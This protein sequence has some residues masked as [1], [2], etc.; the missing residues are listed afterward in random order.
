MEHSEL[1]RLRTLPKNSGVNLGTGNSAEPKVCREFKRPA[2]GPRSERRVTISLAR[3]THSIIPS[4]S[5]VGEHG[6]EGPEP[7]L[8]TIR[9]KSFTSNTRW[10]ASLGLGSKLKCS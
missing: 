8:R 7:H 5:S 10:Y 1:E 2:T 3:F 6:S 4:M 9:I